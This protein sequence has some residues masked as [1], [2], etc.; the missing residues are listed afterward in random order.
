MDLREFQQRALGTDQPDR[1]DDALAVHI[2][3]L[4]GEAGSVASEYK[5]HLR[6]GPAHSF[7]KAR[8]REELGDVLWYVAAVASH[9]GLDL[10]EVAHA[11]LE[12]TNGRWQAKLSDQ[13]DADFPR[14]EQ[15]P[16]RGMIDLVA[17]R[18]ADGSPVV[19]MM[20]EGSQIGDDLTDASPVDD[21]YRYHDVFHLGFAALLGWS[22]VTRALLGRKR[23]SDPTVD[24]QEDGGRAVAIEEGLSAAV[25]AYASQHDFLL[26]VERLDQALL[27]QIDQLTGQ[28]EV[29]VRTPAQWER[30]ILTAFAVWRQV[31]LAGSG[32]IIFDSD[33]GI[34]EYQPAPSSS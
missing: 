19:R 13:F 22:P 15:L 1:S 14:D 18:R 26:G 16:R 20:F 11:N 25:F 32:R 30:A 27:T 5:K 24:E 7:W 34:F 31:R 28:L 29:G 23:R 21:G 33:A 6:D 10:N 12:K 17:G 3:G 9:L 8:M 2:L 4:A